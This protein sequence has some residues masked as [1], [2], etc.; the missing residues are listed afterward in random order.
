MH[1]EIYQAISASKSEQAYLQL[2]SA[3]KPDAYLLNISKHQKQLTGKIR[4]KTGR[5]REREK[6]TK[7]IFFK[8]GKIYTVYA[9]IYQIKRKF[10]EPLET[11]LRA[12]S[13]NRP[14]GIG[15]WLFW[16]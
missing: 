13:M 1:P 4:Q 5:N 14:K 11:I 16:I 9:P 3:S 2:S 10:P 6:T 7:E 12:I 8:K 15:S